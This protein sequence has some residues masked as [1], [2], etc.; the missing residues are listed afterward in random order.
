MGSYNLTGHTNENSWEDVVLLDD[1]DVIQDY[2]N[3][4]EEIKQISHALTLDDLQKIKT[5]PSGFALKINNVP[6][7][8]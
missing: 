6:K 5:N 3:R 1:K 2:L 4:F 8:I 7:K